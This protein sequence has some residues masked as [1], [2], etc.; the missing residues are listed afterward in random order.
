M[1]KVKQA[2]KETDEYMGISTKFQ[3][4]IVEQEEPI[5][6]KSLLELGEQGWELIAIE[7]RRSANLMQIFRHYYSL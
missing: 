7:S 5:N 1:A 2:V 4:K 6:E 3:Y